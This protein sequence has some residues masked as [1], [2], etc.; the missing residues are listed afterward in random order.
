MLAPF[1]LTQINGA[2][3]ARAQGREQEGCDEVQNSQDGAG[4]RHVGE[5]CLYVQ[6]SSQVPNML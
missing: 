6:V 4:R 2:G 1:L 3:S 5:A